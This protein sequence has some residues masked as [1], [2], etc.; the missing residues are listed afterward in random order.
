MLLLTVPGT[1][2]DRVIFVGHFVIVQKRL[3]RQCGINRPWLM[4]SR[5][6]TTARPNVLKASRYR[7]TVTEK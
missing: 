6:S 4:R 7:S 1:S 5:G 3:S 2:G